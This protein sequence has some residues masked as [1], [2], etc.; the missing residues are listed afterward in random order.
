MAWNDYIT[1]T[2]DTLLNYTARGKNATFYGGLALT[3]IDVQNKGI[4]RFIL[5]DSLTSLQTI[6]ANDCQLT[7]AVIPATLTALHWI[8]VVALALWLLPGEGPQGWLMAL[9][10]GNAALA[11][12]YGVTLHLKTRTGVAGW[13]MAASVAGGAVLFALATVR[14]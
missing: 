10:G 4:T 12:A 5:S 13:A 9:I 14:A 2:G 7:Q 1:Q 6:T 3:N 11:L 8:V